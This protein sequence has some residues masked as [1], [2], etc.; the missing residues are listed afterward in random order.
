MKYVVIGLGWRYNFT[1]Y[2]CYKAIEKA[3]EVANEVHAD[4][5][6]LYDDSLNLLA[7]CQ[8]GVLK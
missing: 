8:E 7:D 1:A 3:F 4:T 6:L 2:D 5:W